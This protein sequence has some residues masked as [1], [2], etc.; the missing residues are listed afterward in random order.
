MKYHN[1]N[2]LIA[3]ASIAGLAI[4]AALGILFAP[5]NG[6][7]IRSK[8]KFGN[9]KTD[10]NEDDLFTDHPVEDLWETTRD[11]A[12][13]LQGPEKKRK[14]PS[15]IKVPS[16]GTLAWTENQENESKHPWKEDNHAEG[17]Y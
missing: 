11:H 16:A 3:V 10:H 12:D 4:G 6:R 9:S 8:L 13:H 15:R 2:T 7:D 1:N 5:K 17:R 14:N